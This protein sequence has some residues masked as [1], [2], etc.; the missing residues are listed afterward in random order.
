MI[1]K[2]GLVPFPSGRDLFGNVVYTEAK[3][4]INPQLLKEIS[5]RTHALAFR[6]TDKES[7]RKDLHDALDHLE[8]SKFEDAAS[9]R[10]EELFMRFLPLGLALIALE[11]LLRLTRFAE[12]MD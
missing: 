10:K 11:R 4:P 5:D 6:A 7:L 12:A 8:K 2:D 9:T 3:F 1:G